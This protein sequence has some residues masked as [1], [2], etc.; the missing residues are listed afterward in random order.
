MGI[1]EAVVQRILCHEKG[2]VVT[3]KHYIQTDTPQAVVAM[4][5]FEEQWDM[6]G[7]QVD[8]KRMN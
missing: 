4:K 7:R 2:S 6:I 5:Q 1:S 8:D 3:G